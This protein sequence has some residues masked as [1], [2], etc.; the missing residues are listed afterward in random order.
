MAFSVPRFGNPFG[1]AL[2]PWVRRLIL[3]NVVIALLGWVVG[4]LGAGGLLTS[5]FALYPERVFA[6][7]WTLLSYMFLHAGLLHLLF[8]MIGLFFFG[9]PLEERWGSP[10]FPRFYLVCGLGGGL[11]SLL[12][13]AS[14][15]TVILGASG[16]VL[17]LL[18]A[19][20]MI[21]PDN[22][23]Y[24]YGILPIKAKWLVAGIVALNV[25]GALGGR[26]GGVAYLA[27]LGGLGAGFLYLKSPWAPS[28]YGGLIPARRKPR[29]HPWDALRGKLRRRPSALGAETATEPTRTGQPRAPVAEEAALADVDRILDKI[30]ERGIASLTE[31]ERRR[32][33]EVSRRY[34][35]N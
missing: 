16:A 1:F 26:G 28:P 9:P 23:I 3:A 6:R 11:L 2:T 5:W 35:S 15:A 22:S 14:A 32:L 20:A 33:D 29:T 31:P 13:P 18:L 27:H 21:W 17:G 12:L 24:L 34:R 4:L 19:Y 10:G 30:S 8:N 7:P 25:L